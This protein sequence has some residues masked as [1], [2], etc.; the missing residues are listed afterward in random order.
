MF[1]YNNKRKYIENVVNFFNNLKGYMTIDELNMLFEC[2]NDNI[3]I[4]LTDEDYNICN[5]FIEIDDYISI[6]QYFE[7][8][9][10]KKQIDYDN[11]IINI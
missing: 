5:E 9:I 4:K 10:N 11:Q 1:I 3:D 8:I 7:N 6:C 2:V